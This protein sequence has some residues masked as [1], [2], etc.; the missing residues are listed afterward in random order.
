MN[1][2]RSEVNWSPVRKVVFSSLRRYITMVRFWFL[3]AYTSNWTL[4]DSLIITQKCFWVTKSQ[5]SRIQR[6]QMTEV[7]ILYSLTHNDSCK[8]EEPLVWVLWISSKI[9]IGKLVKVLI[10]ELICPVINERSFEVSLITGRTIAFHLCLKIE[11][12][13]YCF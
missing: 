5:G 9:L 10:E 7:S 11:Y 3:L 4:L 2:V 8:V 12:M 6:H 1:K 13:F